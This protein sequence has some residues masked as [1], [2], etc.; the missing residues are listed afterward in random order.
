MPAELGK[1]WAP[2]P[3]HPCCACQQDSALLATAPSRAPHSD[4]SQARIQANP[5]RGTCWQQEAPDGTVPEHTA[6]VS[7]CFARGFLY[8]NAYLPWVLL[9]AGAKIR[10][11]VI[12][13]SFQDMFLL[14]REQ[15]TLLFF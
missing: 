4:E 1:G 14:E 7:V 6:R 11:S 13:L 8:V 10:E 5:S 9:G 3:P 12:N 2:C 15:Q